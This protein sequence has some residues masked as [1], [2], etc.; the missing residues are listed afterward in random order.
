MTE[1]K[2][3]AKCVQWFRNT[4]PEKRK[5]LF[6][7]HNNSDNYIQ[8]TQK[9]AM[10]MEAGASDLCYVGNH[11][12]IFLECKVPGSKHSTDSIKRQL[13]FADSVSNGPNCYYRVF[14]ILEQFQNIIYKGVLYGYDQAY[15][16]T[17]YNLNQKSITI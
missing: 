10:G 3:Q 15:I 12:V 11:Q 8:A 4:F 9:K 2:L 5:R 17:T 14:T 6:M 1:K 13:L 7:I 16:R